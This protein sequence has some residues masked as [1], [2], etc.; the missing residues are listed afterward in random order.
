MSTTAGLSSIGVY[1]PHLRVARGEAERAVAAADED[2]LTL[3]VEA[4]HLCLEE[5]EPLS[6]GGLFFASVTPSEDERQRASVLASV[7]DLPRDIAT[8]DFGG[9][10]RAGLAALVAAVRA[11]DAGVRK[12]L[13]VA[14]DCRRPAARAGG[15][16]DGAVAL[17]IDRKAAL[18]RFAGSAAV[19]WDFGFQ[20]PGAR[21][22][23]G[24][25]R[26]HRDLAE[27]V[28]RVINEC[29]VGYEEIAWLAVGSPGARMGSKVAEMVGID[30]SA[31]LADGHTRRV[32]ILGTADPLVQLAT[33][34][35]GAT[36]GDR[37]VA[38][39]AGEGAEAILLEAGEGVGDPAHDPKAAFVR[40]R[41][42]E[43]APAPLAPVFG[44][45]EVDPAAI[46]RNTRLYGTRCAACSA[47]QFPE[48]E[49][50]ASCGA[51]EG[52][53]PAKLGKRGR[54]VAT[55]AEKCVVEVD[56]GGRLELASTDAPAGGLGSGT[57][58]W[59]TFR[60]ATSPG[61]PRYAWK[62]RPR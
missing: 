7:C 33:A 46:E 13:V 2:T 1:V 61:G 51:R 58:V 57:N 6:I 62:A 5:V 14:S 50:C 22:Q 31:R 60:R 9:S 56:G 26:P 37:I 25:P 45:T 8:A 52:L 18:A 29:G 44:S 40:R 43:T 55:A 32:G 41:A 36:A 12:V 23:A 4:A 10:T 38:A 28:E 39:A 27:V 17:V 24:E 35:H 48:V 59:L 21:D 30:A 53:E 15:L 47:V 11:V 34:L 54:V 20:H 49:K 42:V 19:A 3:A 16:G